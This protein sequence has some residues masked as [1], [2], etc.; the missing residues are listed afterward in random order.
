VT[1]AVG[2]LIGLGGAAVLA[3]PL[4]KLLFGVKPS[5]PATLGGMACLLL[6]VA[7]VSSYIPARR[8]AR[9]DPLSSVRAE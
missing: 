7:G 8:A 9:I 2:T 1:A 5:D 6:A 4:E 3:R